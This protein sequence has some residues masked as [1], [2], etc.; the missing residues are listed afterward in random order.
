MW[1]SGLEV[2]LPAVNCG[3]PWLS[4]PAKGRRLQHGCVGFVGYKGSFLLLLSVIIETT[5]LFT[6]PALNCLYLMQVQ[7][8]M[9]KSTFFKK[10]PRLMRF[11]S[12]W[13]EIP[14][15]P[16]TKLSLSSYKHQRLLTNVNL[17]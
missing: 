10:R 4:P 14:K 9:L 16:E 17:K 12:T 6:L 13:L 8:S 15:S 3:W 11:I 7:N 1:F 5:M 2:G